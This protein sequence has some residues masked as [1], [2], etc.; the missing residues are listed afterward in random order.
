[1]NDY[2]FLVMENQFL[3]AH[4]VIDGNSMPTDVENLRRELAQAR[5]QLEHAKDNERI[6]N[7][8]NDL[9]PKGSLRRKIVKKLFMKKE[10]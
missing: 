4:V 10:K 8:L 2:S 6:V 3:K 7:K 5:E 9:L 1:M